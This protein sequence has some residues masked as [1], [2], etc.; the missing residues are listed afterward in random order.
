M[1][2][3]EYKDAMP[4]GE[5]T[6]GLVTREEAPEG[7]AIVQ[8]GE[9]TLPFATVGSLTTNPEALAALVTAPELEFD[10]KGEYWSPE[11]DGERKRLVFQHIVEKE[12]NPNKYGDGEIVYLDVAYFVEVYQEDGEP[13]QR[14]LRSASTVLV[15][16]LKK[17]NVPKH[18]A[19]DVVY[20]G[21]KK[22]DKY[23]YDDFAIIPVVV[24]L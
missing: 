6:T 2:K 15:S 19:I 14:M 7:S 12:P 22:G 4:D 1:E 3:Q 9:Q 11:K 23:M 18:A 8:A 16:F 21:K 17:N 13:K 20:K 24:D 10:M 5:N